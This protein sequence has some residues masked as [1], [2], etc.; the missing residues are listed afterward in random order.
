MP[1]PP[2]EK[3]LAR[4]IAL[5]P[6][7]HCAWPTDSL[8]SHNL[9]KVRGSRRPCT[10]SEVAEGQTKPQCTIWYC[11][12]QTPA[13]LLVITPGVL[14]RGHDNLL[15]D[16][17]QMVRGLIARHHSLLAGSGGLQALTRNHQGRRGRPV[18][19]ERSTAIAPAA[20]FKTCAELFGIDFLVGISLEQ[21]RH[22]AAHH[23]S[24]GFLRLDRLQCAHDHVD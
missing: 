20:F 16:I 24:S 15:D 22:A 3:M 19:N 4:P 9:L 11:D 13:A 12:S 10:R 23:E 5:S 2:M 21:D 18:G 17:H 6:P 8:I 1:Q 7:R 14:A